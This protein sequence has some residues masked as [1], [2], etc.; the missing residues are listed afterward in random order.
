MQMFRANAYRGKRLVLTGWVK[1]EGVRGWAGLWMRV[2]GPDN[3][4]LAFDN[5]QDRPIVGSS[6][7]NKY[8]VVLEVPNISDYVAFGLLLQ[9]PGTV[10]MADLKLQIGGKD[11]PTTNSTDSYPEAPD[12]LSFDK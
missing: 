10:W 8:Q 2:D 1:S 5:M 9:G 11:V 6:S 12:N 4:M 3:K 7:W